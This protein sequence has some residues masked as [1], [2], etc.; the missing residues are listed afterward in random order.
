[1][2]RE[3]CVE[4]VITFGQLLYQF[5][6]AAYGEASTQGVKRSALG[7]LNSALINLYQEHDW[8]WRTQLTGLI[9]LSTDHT[10]GTITLTNGS[11]TVTGDANANFDTGW[12]GRWLRADTTGDQTPHPIFRV[13]S[14]T[15]LVLVN[16]WQGTTTAGLSYTIKQFGYN[17][18]A[19]FGS[20]LSDGWE[21]DR[22]IKLM[23]G[24]LDN[25]YFHIN[26]YWQDNQ[27]QYFY[28]Q[29]PLAGSRPD[30]LIWPTAQTTTSVT[31]PYLRNMKY[32]YFYWDLGDASTVN[33]DAT[34]TGVSTNWQKVVDVNIKYNFFEIFDPGSGLYIDFGNPYTYKVSSITSDT[35]L[36]LTT[37][38]SQ[39]TLSN[40]SYIISDQ[41]LVP[42]YMIPTLRE[43][44]YLVAAKEKKD[45]DLIAL[46]FSAYRQALNAAKRGDHIHEESI[47][48]YPTPYPSLFPQPVWFS[49]E[50]L[51]A[52]A[53]T[54]L[55]DAK[56]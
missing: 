55:N 33:G 24:S 44:I 15:E 7:I 13:N 19:N 51:T 8:N 12:Y 10:A 34:V 6:F 30:I 18:P 41:V 45:K 23:E 53:R 11:T 9:N 16:P 43:M 50:N 22:Q 32:P 38:W 29:K 21:T 28:V 42:D 54:R 47:T 3:A 56:V 26:R 35:E 25:F 39:V 20:Y 49:N 1:M 4:N 52:A 36:E 14:A 17:L 27:P 48:P 31:Y 46:S 40:K 5:F 37:N 2:P